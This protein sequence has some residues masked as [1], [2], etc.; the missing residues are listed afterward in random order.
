MIPYKKHVIRQIIIILI[1]NTII[2]YHLFCQTKI[3]YSL[4]PKCRQMPGKLIRYPDSS[5]AVEDGCQINSEYFLIPLYD[6][7]EPNWKSDYDLYIIRGDSIKDLSQRIKN[8][9]RGKLSCQINDSS[10]VIIEF[11]IYRWDIDSIVFVSDSPPYDRLFS[12]SELWVYSLEDSLLKRIDQDDCEY[13][14]F[15]LKDNILYVNVKDKYGKKLYL[16]K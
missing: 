14:N 1:L 13:E 8:G 16:K 6:V 3:N 7:N 5:N 11:D 15:S 9:R 2:G 4:I 10:K 12:Y